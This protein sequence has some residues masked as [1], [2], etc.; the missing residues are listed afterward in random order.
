MKSDISTVLV[1]VLCVFLAGCGAVAGAAI[2]V[3]QGMRIAN[4]AFHSYKV[5]QLAKGGT[6]EVEFENQDAPDLLSGTVGVYPC[7]EGVKIAE[8]L[9]SKVKVITPYEMEKFLQ[10]GRAGMNMTTQEKE[11]HF[12]E[13]SRKAKAEILVF[14][15]NLPKFKS[16][17]L[18]FSQDQATYLFKVQLFSAGGKIFSEEG[19][20]ILR[21]R[22]IPLDKS[23][24]D[25]LVAESIAQ[26]FTQK[27]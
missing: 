10:D 18:S 17:A 12:Q 7:S 16:G 22:R 25:Q 15:L 14:T 19:K 4:V 23:E 11:K 9:A 8:A 26:R 21:G 24:I 6:A 3:I 20:I 13:T 27:T 5:T 1:L 2:P